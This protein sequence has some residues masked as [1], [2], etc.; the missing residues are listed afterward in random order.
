[1]ALRRPGGR[2]GLV[3]EYNLPVPGIGMLVTGH[4][5]DNAV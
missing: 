3:P 2:R 5:R 1:M 4:D